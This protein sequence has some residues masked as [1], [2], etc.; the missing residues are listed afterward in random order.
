[1]IATAKPCPRDDSVPAWHE[2]FLQMLPAIQKHARH[3][4]RRLDPEARAESVQEVVAGAFVA[5]V[6]LVELGKANLAFATPLAMYGIR[7][8]RAGRKVG[9]KLNV[10][11]ATSRH[12]Q[13]VKGVRVESLDG[14]SDDEEEWREIL[15]EDR[16][17]GPSEIAASRIDIGDWL[18]FLPTRDRR[19][20]KALAT[21]EST[22]AVARKFKLSSGRIS[23]L[24]REL[25]TSWETFQGEAEVDL[26]VA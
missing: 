8:V 16:H 9:A 12:C 26:A 11:D 5:F 7:H 19:I 25:K 24:R 15:L 17:A 14:F 18:R 1:M 4:F 20:A 6:R 21:G 10:R 23:Q 2:P 22:G 13:L 3:A